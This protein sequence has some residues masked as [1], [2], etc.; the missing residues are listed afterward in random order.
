MHKWLFEQSGR[1]T[2]QTFSTDLVNL[3]FDPRDFVPVMMSDVT[4]QRVKSESNDGFA[5]GVYYTPMVFINGVEYLWYY[6]RRDSLATIVDSVAKNI[7]AGGSKIKAPPNASEKLVEDWRVGK[8]FD[9]PGHSEN[10]WLGNG[11]IEFVVWGD[12]QAPLSVQ[13]D[14]EVQKLIQE[15]NSKIRYSFRNF[16]ID[17]SCNAG[18][19][20]M[21]TKYNGSCNLS[22]LVE[23]VSVLGGSGPRWKMHDWILAQPKPVNLGDARTQAAILAGVDEAT[24]EDVVGSI[25]VGNRMRLDI[26]SKNLVWRKAIPVIT[27][28]GRFVP[29]WRSEA[30]PAP[31][32]FHRI[33][34]AVESEGNNK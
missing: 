5:L 1:F 12:Y 30:V 11:P 27:I 13:L 19:A 22:K 10:S 31:D 17:E 24:I 4:L 9:P 16:P 25:D 18:V 26:M 23:S 34:D 7:A 6:G 8:T 3:G 20:N 33:I 15:E 32:V 21:P 2:D 29:R 14:A 28:D